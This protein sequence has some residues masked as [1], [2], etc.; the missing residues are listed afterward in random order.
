MSRRRM[1]PS[2]SNSQCSLPRVRYHWPFESCHSYSKGTEI[3]INGGEHEQGHQGGTSVSSS[4]K[5]MKWSE[6]PR[7]KVAD[8]FSWAQKADAAPVRTFT[9]VRHVRNRPFDD[10]WTQKVTGATA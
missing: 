5:F 4:V 3:R 10:R 6:G 1:S 2:S 9:I 8:S 7:S